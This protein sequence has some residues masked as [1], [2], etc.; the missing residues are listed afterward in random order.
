MPVEY[1]TLSEIR[2]RADAIAKALESLLSIRTVAWKPNAKQWIFLRESLYCLLS[3]AHVSL[4]CDLTAVHAAQLKFEIEDTLRK[5]YLRPGKP[6][7]YVLSLVHQSK[8]SNY[9]V[10]TPEQYPS[11]AG[12]CLLI[13]SITDE[14]IGV[15]VNSA[16][17]IKV[18]LER[19][20]TESVDAEYRAYAALPEICTS[21]L[22]NWFC[23]D[24]PAI[25]E[26]T[27]LL[28]RHQKK[29]W[30][31]SNPLN[32][33]TKRLLNVKVKTITNHEAIVATMEYWYL[34]WWDSVN[35]IYVYPYRETNR[36]TY[37]LRHENAVWRVF[38]NIRPLPRTSIPYRWHIR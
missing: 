18:Y 25:N 20:V 35:D 10:E 30:I 32:P 31:I 14:Q 29:G 7:D 9:G 37:I 28:V 3:P 16:S 6:V 38:E 33:S 15:K 36:Q 19:V 17:D 23:P 21:E 5:Y 2:A 26:I 22:N 4:F 24:G 12:Y 8:L 34:R 27:N 1:L 13:R 11:L